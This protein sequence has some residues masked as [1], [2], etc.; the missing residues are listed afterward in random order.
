MSFCG[1]SGAT[2]IRQTKL[3]N[4]C[5]GEKEGLAQLWT[6]LAQDKVVLYTT[7]ETM[8]VLAPW[9]LQACGIVNLDK[10]VA[11]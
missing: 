10:L 2:T 3:G 1:N 9:L 7:K 5:R 11:H 8:V 6:V 4:D